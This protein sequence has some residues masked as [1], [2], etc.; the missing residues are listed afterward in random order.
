M[1]AHYG[2]V[3]GLV[4]WGALSG[5]TGAGRCLISWEMADFS[6]WVWRGEAAAVEKQRPNHG[7]GDGS[8]Q[9]T[10][11]VRWVSTREDPVRC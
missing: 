4:A 7:R 9:E 10:R 3:P 8:V 11:N 6:P 2:A 5:E 1:G